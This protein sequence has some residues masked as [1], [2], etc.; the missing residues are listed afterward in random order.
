MGTIILNGEDGNKFVGEDF[1]DVG[2]EAGE[3][4]ASI[5]GN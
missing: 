2:K 1:T 5:F 3:E 4:D